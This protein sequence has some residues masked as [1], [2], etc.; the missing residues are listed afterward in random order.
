MLVNIEAQFP[1]EI[2]AAAN[3]DARATFRR[4]MENRL[5]PRMESLVQRIKAGAKYQKIA[6][7]YELEQ[8]STPDTIAFA[9]INTNV[10]SRFLIGGSRPHLIPHAFGR[11]G[12]VKHPG[13]K[14]D[15][16]VLNAVEGAEPA[17]LD[18]AA[19]AGDRW[20][21]SFGVEG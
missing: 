15:E 19:D 14:P 12:A 4:V 11:P 8:K 16:P 13:I 18:A 21:R 5:R 2:D 6:P 9:V 3:V 17:L 20:A 1:K 10:H 7:A